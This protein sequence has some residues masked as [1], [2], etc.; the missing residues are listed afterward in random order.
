[1]GKGEIKVSVEAKLLVLNNKLA[2]YKNS[3]YDAE[4]DYSVGTVT[5]DDKLK[6]NAQERMKTYLKAIEA[7]EKM[8]AEVDDNA[9][10]DA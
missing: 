8:L 3:F 5:D 7:L 9:K 10:N 1:M 2:I 4:I 6:E